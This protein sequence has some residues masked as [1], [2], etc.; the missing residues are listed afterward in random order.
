MDTRV[1]KIF[2]KIK[3]SEQVKPL[4]LTLGNLYIPDKVLTAYAKLCTIDRSLGEA[5]ADMISF[6]TGGFE[7]RY[8]D[9]PDKNKKRVRDLFYGTFVEYMI[10][11]IDKMEFEGVL[12]YT[13]AQMLDIQEVWE[14]PD[15][16]DAIIEKIDS[17]ISGF[18]FKT[19]PGS[20]YVLK[21]VVKGLT[22]YRFGFDNNM[23]DEFFG[24]CPSTTIA[25]ISLLV[26]D[27]DREIVYPS[28][29]SNENYFE[30]QYK[31]KKQITK[32]IDEVCNRTMGH[33]LDNGLVKELV[34]SYLTGITSRYD[35]STEARADVPLS[36][37][38]GDFEDNDHTL[39]DDV[40][41]I[42]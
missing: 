12:D 4:K 24:A 30:I 39:I 38:D 10:K 19:Y 41:K 37:A 7:E 13:K 6:N 23:F 27:V 1:R 2:D 42:L 31:A 17:S 15:G 5:Y 3:L 33:K 32:V 9:D 21:S 26:N 16:R 22:N 20:E 18:N 14:T 8:M 40:L 25:V 28:Y 36:F 11:N 34:A 29:K 35:W